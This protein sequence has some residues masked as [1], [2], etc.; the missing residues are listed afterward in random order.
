MDGG[1]DLLIGKS[2]LKIAVRK[3]R[4]AGRTDSMAVCAMATGAT[5]VEKLSARLGYR[6]CASRMNGPGGHV[7]KVGLAVYF[8]AHHRVGGIEI[9]GLGSG[10]G[11]VLRAGNKRSNQG[12]RGHDWHAPAWTGIQSHGTITKA[13]DAQ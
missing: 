3:V 6:W 7:H 1:G 8:Q 12:N 11:N 4:S 5:L 13:Q 10:N 2:R 9:S